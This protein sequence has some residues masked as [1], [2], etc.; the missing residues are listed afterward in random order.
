[1]TGPIEA[2][3]IDSVRNPIAAKRQRLDRPA[4]IL[5]AKA[6]RRAPPSQRARCSMKVRKLTLSVS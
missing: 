3:R 4:G 5:A 2:G 6:Q 1:L